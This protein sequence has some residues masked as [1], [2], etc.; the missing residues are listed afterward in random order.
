[1]NANESQMY[2]LGRQAHEAGFGIESCNLS[3]YDPRRAFWIA[4]WI[5]R[6]IESGNRRYWP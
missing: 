4:G 5:D 1:M 6:D 3:E 2:N